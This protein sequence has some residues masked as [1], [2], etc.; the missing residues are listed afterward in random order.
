MDEVKTLTL[1]QSSRPLF[2]LWG[3]RLQLDAFK[4]TL[5][6]QNVQLGPSGYDGIEGFVPL[7]KVI[8]AARFRSV[9]LRLEGA[10]IDYFGHSKFISHDV[11]FIVLPLATSVMLSP[12]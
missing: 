6:S 4:S 2:Q 12:L 8:Q 5:H 11:S 10:P 1:T 7:G 3:G 9:Q